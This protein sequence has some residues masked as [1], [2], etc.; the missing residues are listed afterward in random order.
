MTSWAFENKAWAGA[1]TFGL[2]I[3]SGYVLEDTRHM[4]ISVFRDVSWMMA[5]L[6]EESSKHHFFGAS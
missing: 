6:N 1:L 3:R 2:V 5:S 4:E